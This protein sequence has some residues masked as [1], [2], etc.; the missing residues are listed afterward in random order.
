[1]LGVIERL[2]RKPFVAA[3]AV[4]RDA[5][6]I[7][8]Q[9]L[10]DAVGHRGVGVGCHVTVQSSA[11]GEPFERREEW[12]DLAD[13]GPDMRRNRPGIGQFVGCRA[14]LEPVGIALNAGRGQAALALQ[15]VS[16]GKHRRR[17]EPA[18]DIAGNWQMRAR[19]AAHA[20]GKD[21]A[22]MRL[23]IL[24]AF[25]SDRHLLRG[26]PVGAGAQA[27]PAKT[28]PCGR[29]EAHDP[30]PDGFAACDPLIGH[31]LG[32][33]AAVFLSGDAGQRQN[34]T[35]VRCHD[36]PFAVPIIV[37]RLQPGMVAGA[38][39]FAAPCVP[40]HKGEFTLK[41]ARAVI[42][43]R[44]IGAQHKLGV[45]AIAQDRPA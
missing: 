30:L 16:H 10:T 37:Q 12:L 18:A 21:F 44:F 34:C 7:A 36:Q 23:V 39:G 19:G 2:A 11:F 15:V 45:R 43:P 3:F 9:R 4:K 22:I 42:A 41:M 29:E 35:L 8:G 33:H 5:A 28:H 31:D 26:C 24:I 27:I 17:I 38:K 1:M 6:T 13:F 14:F 32:N 20:F 40:D 25:V